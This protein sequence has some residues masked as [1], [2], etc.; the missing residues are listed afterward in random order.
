MG[1]LIDRCLEKEPRDRIQAATE[2][3][4]ELKAYRRAWETGVDSSARPGAPDGTPRPAEHAASI[5]VL[6][7]TD[8]SAA[9]DQDW[10]CDGI[11]E[12]ILNALTP[13]KG[14]RVAART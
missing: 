14:L 11:A 6:A 12:E 7:F 13:L 8:M 4:A 5:A 9:K 3:L 10:F 1:R 2:I